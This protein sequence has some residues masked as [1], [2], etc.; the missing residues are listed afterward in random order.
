MREANDLTV[1]GTNPVHGE[2]PNVVPQY[3]RSPLIYRGEIL[4][5]KAPLA[6][7]LSQTMPL[8]VNAVAVPQLA[9]PQ[10]LNSGITKIR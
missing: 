10:I 4:K 2:L 6:T 3:P 5:G 1:M 8:G 9:L 7:M